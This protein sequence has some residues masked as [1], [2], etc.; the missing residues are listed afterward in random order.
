M[1]ARTVAAA[2]DPCAWDDWYP[3]VVGRGAQAP[4]AQIGI[5]HE[6]HAEGPRHALGLRIIETDS[7]LR[8]VFSMHRA[9]VT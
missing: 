6:R 9:R 1:P 3:Q 5:D 4:V 2:P 8:I 7:N